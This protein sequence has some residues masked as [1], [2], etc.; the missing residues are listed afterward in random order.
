VKVR[1]KVTTANKYYYFPWCAPKP[2]KPKP[3]A[4]STKKTK[5]I[6]TSTPAFLLLSEKQAI[7]KGYVLAKACA[8]S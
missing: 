7:E 4:T 1:G 3:G 5:K 8:P 6:A 2:P